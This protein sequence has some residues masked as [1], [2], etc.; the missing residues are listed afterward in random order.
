MENGN[1]HSVISIQQTTVKVSGH[2]TLAGNF[3]G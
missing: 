1:Q 3:F 2:V